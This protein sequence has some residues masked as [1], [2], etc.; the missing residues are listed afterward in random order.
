MISKKTY[1]RL[2]SALPKM[3]LNDGEDD[4][5]GFFVSKFLKSLIF[6]KNPLIIWFTHSAATTKNTVT[7]AMFH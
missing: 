2:A 7:W 5:L 4:E 3:H 6:L 1:S